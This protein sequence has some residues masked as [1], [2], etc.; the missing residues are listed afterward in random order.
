MTVQRREG[1]RPF[2]PRLNGF[3][4]ALQYGGLPFPLFIATE[5][6]ATQD[7]PVF[8]AGSMARCWY[9]LPFKVTL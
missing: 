1:V 6:D 5:P 8:P 7:W 9:M 2:N 4:F 3:V